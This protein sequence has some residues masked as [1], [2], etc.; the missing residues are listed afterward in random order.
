[1][2]VVGVLDLVADRAV[3]A[4]GGQRSLY[5]PVVMVAGEPI[6]PGH[7]PDLARAYID[8]LGLDEIYVA[9]LTAIAAS[10]DRARHHERARAEAPRHASTL[11]GIT[12][13][14][15]VVWLDA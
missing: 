8:R 11:D 3:H 1:M 14:G 10:L 12:A 15:A 13:S 6:Q 5:E 4:R 9:D 2:R 7:A